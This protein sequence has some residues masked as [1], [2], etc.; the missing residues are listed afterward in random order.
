MVTAY[1]DMKALENISE[2][3]QKQYQKLYNLAHDILKNNKK[4][5]YKLLNTEQRK[6]I[7]NFLLKFGLNE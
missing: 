7:E 6:T 2:K 3:M 4:E 1:N 5:I